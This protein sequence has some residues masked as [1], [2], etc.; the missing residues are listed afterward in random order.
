MTRPSWTP[1]ALRYAEF[2]LR[3]AEDKTFQLWFAPIVCDLEEIHRVCALQVE[4]DAQ[5][6]GDSPRRNRRSHRGRS[7]SRRG[8]GRPTSGVDAA[9]VEGSRKRVDALCT[10]LRTLLRDLVTDDDLARFPWLVTWC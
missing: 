6:G 7:P 5:G 9:W 10:A 1:P 3:L 4:A 2:R 8:Q